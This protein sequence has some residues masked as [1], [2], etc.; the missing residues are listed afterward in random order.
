MSSSIENKNWKFHYW[1]CFPFCKNTAL[2]TWNDYYITHHPLSA[3]CDDTNPS[4]PTSMLQLLIFKTF[5]LKFTQHFIAEPQWPAWTDPLLYLP[6][7]LLLFYKPEDADCG[8]CE[9][10]LCE[11][12][13]R[14]IVSLHPGLEQHPCG[15]RWNR[16]FC[17][18]SHGKSLLFLKL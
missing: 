10:H 11:L 9:L 4:E 6:R 3:L 2:G 18:C 8:R 14:C 13:E 17:K 7:V 5:S 12:E 1:Y 15:G 16:L